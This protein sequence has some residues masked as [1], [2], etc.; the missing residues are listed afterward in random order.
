MS[1]KRIVQMVA[2]N[3]VFVISVR[4]EFM[5]LDNFDNK[6]QRWKYVSDQVMGGVSEGDLIFNQDEEETFAHLT[7]VVSTE[8]NGGFIQ[9]RTDIETTKNQ[10]IEGIY[11][12]VKGNNEA[13]FIHLRT[14][15]TFLPW[16]YYQSE[17]IATKNWKIVKLPI[18]EFRASSKWLKNRP[19][20]NSLK[21][22]GIVAFGR[23]HNADISV[24]EVGFY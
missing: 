11:L 3:L 13:Y 20:I 23:E 18:K 24:S 17:F 7:G 4:A 1:L 19:A 22:I 10:N 6:T 16:Q 8:N 2:I 15:G 12:K 9:F 21:S 5:L 14:K